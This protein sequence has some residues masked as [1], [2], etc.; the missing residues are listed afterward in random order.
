MYRDSSIFWSLLIAMVFCPLHCVTENVVAHEA[1]VSA[2]DKTADKASE[3]SHVPRRPVIPGGHC[4][5]PG[6][7]CEGALTVAP[8]TAP[9]PEYSHVEP[10]SCDLTVLPTVLVALA[11]EAGRSLLREHPVAS[12]SISGRH[13]CALISRFLL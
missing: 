1:A 2:A 12:Q 9:V 5:H 3:A 4:H 8:A 6:C 13:L 10:W 7:I 11:D